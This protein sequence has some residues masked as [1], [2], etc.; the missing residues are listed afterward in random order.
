MSSL[1]NN[2]PKFSTSLIGVIGLS[3]LA[4]GCTRTFV[5][6]NYYESADAGSTTKH[7]T[8]RLRSQTPVTQPSS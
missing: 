7:P 8:R 6:N 4:G 1:T 5:T 2:L 3:V